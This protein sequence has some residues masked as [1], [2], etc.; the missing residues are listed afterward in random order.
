MMYEIERNHGQ[1]TEKDLVARGETANYIQGQT[2][3]RDVILKNN[4]NKMLSH[5]SVCREPGWARPSEDHVK[6]LLV[7]VKLALVKLN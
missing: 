2:Q 6:A 5:R 3:P 1:K 4:T 7:V